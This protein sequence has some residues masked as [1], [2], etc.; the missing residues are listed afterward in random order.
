MSSDHISAG[1]VRVPNFVNL[2]LDDANKHIKDGQVDLVLEVEGFENSTVVPENIILSQSLEKGV[3]VATKTHIKLIISKGRNKIAVPNVLFKDYEVAQKELE[4]EG[5]IT[6]KEE[7]ED[8]NNK[9]GAVIEQDPDINKS[10]IQGSSIKLIVAKNNI[11]DDTNKEEIVPDLS[12]MSLEQ[13]KNIL[14]G[15]HLYIV[16][17]YEYSDGIAKDNLISQKSPAGTRL[18]Q[19]SYVEISVSQGKETRLVEEVRSLSFDEASNKL[20]GN[21][22]F[23]NIVREDDFSD[24]VP[25]GNVV[26]QSANYGDILEKGSTIVLVVSKG[27]RPVEQRVPETRRK[28]IEQ[29]Q[30]PTQRQTQESTQK[31]TQVPTQRQTE[32]QTQ[33]AVQTQTPTREKKSAGEDD[34]QKQIDEDMNKLNALN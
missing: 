22:N 17:N 28:D 5:F 34:M 12:G 33:V 31:Q 19:G 26:S 15:L 27:P 21:D 10:A 4:D 18:K 13:A 2:S 30:A 24:N 29:T 3:E 25:I 7:R 6:E 1:K 9:N 23:F 8:F 20:A 11:V 14:K 32:V 16:P